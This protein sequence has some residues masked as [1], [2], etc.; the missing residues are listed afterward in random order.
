MG[1][2]CGVFNQDVFDGKS[3]LCFVSIQHA[4]PILE[5]VETIALYIR[6]QAAAAHRKNRARFAS[7]HFLARR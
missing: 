3:A 1:N 6:L 5:A 4:N 2:P 7:S